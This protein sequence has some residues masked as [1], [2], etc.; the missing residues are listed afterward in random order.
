M[1]FAKEL[2]DDPQ[3][4]L[5]IVL[6]RIYADYDGSVILRQHITKIVKEAKLINN[7]EIDLFSLSSD[8]VSDVMY[9]SRHSKEFL[10]RY[11]STKDLTRDDIQQIIESFK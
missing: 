7:R 1:L 2:K 8:S 9:I 5:E 6:K 11:D 3:L 4:L 10:L